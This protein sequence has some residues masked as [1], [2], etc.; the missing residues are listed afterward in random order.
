MISTLYS[1][2]S[3]T[4]SKD[5]KSTRAGVP[6]GS[7]SVRRFLVLVLMSVAVIASGVAIADQ[8]VTSEAAPTVTVESEAVAQDG[9][10][11]VDIRLSEAPDGVAGFEITVS[12]GDV[13]TARITEA[14]IPEEF[15][16][17]DRTINDGKVTLVASDTGDNFQTGATDVLLGTITVSGEAQGETDLSLTVNKFDADGG[18]RINAETRSGRL[19]VGS[20]ASG[21]NATRSISSTTVQAGDTVEVTIDASLGEASGVQISDAFPSE[22]DAEIVNGFGGLD[23]VQDNGVTFNNPT[24]T[25][26]SYIVTYQITVPE[27]A[28]N[29]ISYDFSGTVQTSTM[30]I[31]GGESRLIVQGSSWYDDYVDDSNVVTTSGLNAAV[32]DYLNPGVALSD[33]RLNALIQSYLSGNPLKT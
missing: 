12:V 31:I 6:Y 26:D 22:L 18:D 25:S 11:T 7:T 14:S 17:R 16:L 1:M 28:S 13:E 10:E 30:A 15:G 21:I 27:D 2:K 4:M 3:R 5:N 32:Q 8:G 23:N 9:T 33:E 29:G 24:G 19:L 20:A